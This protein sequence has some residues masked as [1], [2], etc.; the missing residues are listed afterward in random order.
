MI[1]AWRIVKARHVADAFSGEGARLYGGRWNH[2]G[3][4][5]VYLGGSQALA[6]LEL[7]VHLGPSGGGL[8]FVAIRV[9][10]PRD[11]RIRA[12]R[13]RDLPPSWREQPPSDETKDLGTK[14]ARRGATVVLR[15]PSVIVPAESNYLLNPAHPD[16][17]KLVIGARE[18]FALD[19]RMWK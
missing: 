8:R 1:T 19:P 17:A 11:V 7:F 10:V 6:A 16:F 15:V 13:P 9:D 5:L 12:L 4:P 3:T 18:P 14:W 2:R